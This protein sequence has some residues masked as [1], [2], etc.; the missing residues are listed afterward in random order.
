MVLVELLREAEKVV[1]NSRAPKDIGSLSFKE[2]KVCVDSNPTQWPDYAT[3]A[4]K[5]D[6]TIFFIKLII[7]NTLNQYIFKYK[8]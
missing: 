4:S 1:L 8:K 3:S 6:I 2:N 5:N 7:I